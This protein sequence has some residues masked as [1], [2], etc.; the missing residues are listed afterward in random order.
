MVGRDHLRVPEVSAPAHP[1]GREGEATTEFS[2]S[3]NLTQV[4]VG[5]T[6]PSAASLEQLPGTTG[7]PL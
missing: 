5:T 2:D 7:N 4:I 3:H 1:G 6:A